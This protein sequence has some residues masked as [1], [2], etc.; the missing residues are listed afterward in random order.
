MATVKYLDRDEEEQEIYI[1]EK[2]L[3]FGSSSQCDCPIPLMPGIAGKHVQFFLEDGEYYLESLTKK[4]TRANYAR[5]DSYKPVREGQCVIIRDSLQVALGNYELILQ[6]SNPKY[7]IADMMSESGDFN[8]TFVKKQKVST[9]ESWMFDYLREFHFRLSCT[10]KKSF[11][12]FILKSVME[13]FPSISMSIIYT[14]PIVDKK[15]KI[16]KERYL[17]RREKPE[18]EAS[19]NCI[20]RVLRSKEAHL[21]NVEPDH[22]DENRTLQE[23]SVLS[24]MIFPVFEQDDIIALLYF[25]SDNIIHNE[26]FHK[27][28]QLLEIGGIMNIISFCLFWRER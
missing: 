21:F 17:R 8:M 20:K 15:R 16:K 12:V 13:A 9:P 7:Q 1:T 18:H 27:L 2:P 3:V 14:F 11:D 24:C 23:N 19:K 6:F 5:Q 10:E 28:L 4:E 25:E 26:D 22:L